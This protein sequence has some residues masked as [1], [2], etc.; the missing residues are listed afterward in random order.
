MSQR[1]N[2]IYPRRLLFSGIGSQDTKL[3]E[4]RARQSGCVTGGA[5]LEDFGDAGVVGPDS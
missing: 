1:A 5:A 3:S 2:G 4:P